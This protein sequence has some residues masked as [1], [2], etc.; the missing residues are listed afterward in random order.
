ME[1]GLFGKPQK[2]RDEK[3]ARV[4]TAA[5][6]SS[7]QYTIERVNCVLG[8]SKTKMFEN[9]DEIITCLFYDAIK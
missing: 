9:L 5:V 1:N 4:F 2:T 3:W 6:K 7:A 8:H